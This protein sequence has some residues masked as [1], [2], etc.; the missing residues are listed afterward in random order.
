MGK[1]WYKSKLIW[2]GVIQTLIG[3]LQL[4][5]DMLAKAQ[6]TPADVA[7]FC[8]GVLVVVMR[9]WFTAEPINRGGA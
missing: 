4:L 1:E 3:A 5:G 2:M 9:I 6:V 7:L 8:S